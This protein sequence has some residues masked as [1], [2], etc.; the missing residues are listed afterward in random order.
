M[1][2]AVGNLRAAVLLGVP[3]SVLLFAGNAAL[4]TAI[5]L[6][7]WMLHI[8]AVMPLTAGS[9]AAAYAA[10]RR[11]RHSGIFCGIRVSLYLIG[12]WYAVYC[13]YRGTLCMPKAVLP[14]ILGGIAGGLLGVH[15]EEP[16]PRRRMHRLIGCR[17]QLRMVPL[18]LH[19][20]RNEKKDAE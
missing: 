2:K 18:L 11:Q 17:E 1:Q 8:L 15:R 10:G 3:V 6:P 19:R 20:P 9:F 12:I 14:V 7:G 4:Y 5:D 13:M 16:V